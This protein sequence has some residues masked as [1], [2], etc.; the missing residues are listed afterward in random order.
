MWKIWQ[1]KDQYLSWSMPSKLTFISAYIGFLTLV[2]SARSS[3][4]SYLSYVEDK[5]LGINYVVNHDYDQFLSKIYL[6][7]NGK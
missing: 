2:A 1:S 3:I 6:E 5:N 4:F 7:E